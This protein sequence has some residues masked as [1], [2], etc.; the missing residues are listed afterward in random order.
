MQ[1]KIFRKG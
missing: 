1:E